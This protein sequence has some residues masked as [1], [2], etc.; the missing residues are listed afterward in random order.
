MRRP[1]ARSRKRQQILRHGGDYACDIDPAWS[2]D[3]HWIAF[4]RWDDDYIAVLTPDGSHLAR[5]H[6]VAA[7]T[8]KWP[9]DCST[10][11]FYENGWIVRGL[12]GA[13]KFVQLA[14]SVEGGDWH[15]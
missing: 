3:G 12:G 9:K 2:P 4:T 13:P 5:P 14:K 7:G 8:V 10:L 1:L 15:C 6:R 11:F